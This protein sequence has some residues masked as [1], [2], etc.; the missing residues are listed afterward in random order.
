MPA[1]GCPPNHWFDRGVSI[2]MGLP[3]QLDGLFHGKSMENP[4]D[5]CLGGTPM[6][7][8]TKVRAHGLFGASPQ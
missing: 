1:L 5:E 4:W 7:L 6:T 8:D 2:V 3:Q